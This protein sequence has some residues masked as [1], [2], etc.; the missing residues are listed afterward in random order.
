MIPYD[1]EEACKPHTLQGWVSSNGKFYTD[2]SIARY[3]GCTHRPCDICKKLTNK[4]YL[5]CEECLRLRSWAS[6]NNAPPRE[7]KGELLWSKVNDNYYRDLED[8]YDQELKPEDLQLFVCDKV[9]ASP[10]HTD[11][12]EDSF[13][14]DEHSEELEALVDDFNEKLANL[15]HLSWCPSKYKV[16]FKDT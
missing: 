5:F 4:R 8:I 16:V 13:A 12:W 2:E 11:I 1:S 9:F 3:E 10:L 6:Y 14:D 15:S 7:W